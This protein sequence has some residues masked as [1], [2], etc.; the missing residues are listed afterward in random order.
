MGYSKYK[1]S[2]EGCV[3]HIFNRGNQK[4]KIFYDDSDYRLYLS[5]LEKYSNDLSFQ[6][7]S[8]CLMPNHVHL[9]L[10]QKGEKNP[11]KLISAL[12]TSY[13]MIFNKKY[14]KVG[15][16]FQGRY[17]QK[18][19]AEDE[20]LFQAMSYIY[21]NPVVDGLVK[22]ANEYKWSNCQGQSFEASEYE[23]FN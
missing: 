16:L 22:T 14:G 6:V 20:Y 7:L 15:H 8:Y 19:V 1:E 4:Q 3:Y 2:A 23:G 13:A 21:L 18:I 5:R 11:A 10:K 17:K 12:H 9:L